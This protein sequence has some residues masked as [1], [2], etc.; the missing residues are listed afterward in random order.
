MKIEVGDWCCDKDG[1]VAHITG[2]DVGHPDMYEYGD[3][4]QKFIV[5][6]TPDNDR[7]VVSKNEE[8]IKLIAQLRKRET[9]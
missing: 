9:I 6:I 2:I 8:V 5:E 4:H 7:I 1:N 3:A